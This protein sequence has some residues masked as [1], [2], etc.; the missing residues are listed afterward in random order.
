MDF[1][2]LGFLIEKMAVNVPVISCQKI[3]YMLKPDYTRGY[4]I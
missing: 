4:P 1:H 3:G 2:D